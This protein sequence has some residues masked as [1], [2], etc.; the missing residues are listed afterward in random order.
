GD[1]RFPLEP[2]SVANILVGAPAL[3]PFADVTTRLRRLPGWRTR[4]P[5]KVAFRRRESAHALGVLAERYRAN[6]RFRELVDTTLARVPRA[7]LELL[8]EH[9]PY[10]LVHS[11]GS[12][13]YVNYRRFFEVN[14][15]VALRVEYPTVFFATHERILRW[16]GNRTVAGLRID[17]VDGL[18]DPEAYLETLREA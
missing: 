12:S 4:D 1:L 16:I 9:Q 2:G 15:L 11:R 17:H 7:S 8:L 6:G 5:V 18:A 13:R 14:D 10:R 3:D